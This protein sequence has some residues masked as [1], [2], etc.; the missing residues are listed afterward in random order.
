VIARLAAQLTINYR[1]DKMDH[2][3]DER[4]VMTLD[5]GGTNFVFPQFRVAK[6]LL[7]QSPCRRMLII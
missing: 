5:A 6:K 3:N 1:S 4:I 2:Q 7:N